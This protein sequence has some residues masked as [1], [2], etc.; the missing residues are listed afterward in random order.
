MPDRYVQISS[1]QLKTSNMKNILCVLILV[2]LTSCSVD[3]SRLL[4]NDYR[5][6]ENTPVWT[7]AKAV[8]DEDTSAI[9]K[10][11]IEEKINIDFQEPR[12]GKTLLM[13]T[14]SNHHFNSC[15]ILLQL[16]ADPNK[17]DKYNGSS[18]MIDAA[19]VIEDGEN[20]RFLKL[21]LAHKGNPNY[22]EIGPGQEGNT[23]RKTPLIASLIESSSSLLKVKV[24]V[25]AGADINYKNEYGQ[26]VLREAV[27]QN[28]YE[29]VLYLL[30]KGADYQ[31]LIVDRGQFNTGGKKM[32]LIDMLR[33][34]LP[35]LGSKEHKTKMAIVDFLKQK[36]IDYKQVPIPDYTLK[37]IKETYP[38]TWEEYKD[39]Y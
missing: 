22:I 31:A 35:E 3:K 10:I 9:R 36:G 16:G 39:N 25:E 2:T 21:L 33:E 4:G 7:L 1:D 26:T 37:E 15:K 12:F 24:L 13:L 28:N 18:A 34:D 8:R 27:L 17:P 11:V 32:Y 38:K 6:F 5:L 29:V 23:T 20:I 14:V 19:K 30:E